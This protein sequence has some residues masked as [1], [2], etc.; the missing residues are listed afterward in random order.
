MSKRNKWD[1][2]KTQ[3]G[4]MNVLDNEWKTTP[5]VS[6][7]AHVGNAYSILIGLY[8]RRLVERRKQLFVTEWRIQQPIPE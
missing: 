6:I 1:V 2:T 3:Q 7:N 4:V 8:T 5:Q